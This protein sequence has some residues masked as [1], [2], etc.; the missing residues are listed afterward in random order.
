MFYPKYTSKPI[1]K[2]LA[3][4][5]CEVCIKEIKEGHWKV[6]AHQYIHSQCLE[7]TKEAL[8]YCTEC[9]WSDDSSLAK[10]HATFHKSKTGHKVC[11]TEQL[12]VTYTS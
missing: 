9:E 7:H 1:T 10:R 8:A 3:K 2:C 12:A 6:G 5:K 11:I 4:I